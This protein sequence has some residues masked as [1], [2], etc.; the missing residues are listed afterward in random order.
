MC[1]IDLTVV[2]RNDQRRTFPDVTYHVT[3]GQLHIRDTSEVILDLRD[4][5][6]WVATPRPAMAVPL[7]VVPVA[8][9]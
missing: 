5:Y 7:A 9:A 8:A 1:P 6:G 2:F 3:R 4:V